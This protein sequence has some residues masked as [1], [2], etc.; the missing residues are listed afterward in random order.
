MCKQKLEQRKSLI[1]QTLLHPV[2][3]IWIKLILSRSD[4]CWMLTTGSLWKKCSIMC[5]LILLHTAALNVLLSPLHHCISTNRKATGSLN[6]SMPAVGATAAL[7]KYWHLKEQRQVTHPLWKGTE[8]QQITGK[9][10]HCIGCSECTTKLRSRLV[11]LWYDMKVI[12][13][14]G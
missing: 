2:G 13:A 11:F 14:W 1:Y 4:L 3:L 10:M 7:A 5:P 9:T 8:K 6:L 12:T